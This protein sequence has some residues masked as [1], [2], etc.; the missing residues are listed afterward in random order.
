[1]NTVR[2]FTMQRYKFLKAIH[3]CNVLM[4]FCNIVVSRCKDTSFWKQFTTR[5]RCSPA[6]PA[7]FHDAKIQVFE[8]NSQ[9]L[10]LSIEWELCCFTMQRYKFL[11]A[12]HNCDIDVL[13]GGVV[14][15]RCKDTSFWK[16]FTTGVW[17]RV[18]LLGCFTMQRY[19]FLKAIHNRRGRRQGHLLVVSRYKDTSFFNPG[20][21]RRIKITVVVLW[22]YPNKA[23]S[24]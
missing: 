8:S 22:Y 23:L 3:N 6:W 7:L 14:V 19:K 11:K 13:C 1:M 16:Q 15:S 12:I 5:S 10:A 24:Q 20:W 2:C 18:S 4:S 21:I 17:K 9:P